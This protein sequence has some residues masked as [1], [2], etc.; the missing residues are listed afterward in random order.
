MASAVIVGAFESQLEKKV[1]LAFFLPGVV[2]M[3][4]AVGTQTETVLIG[5]LSIGVSVRSVLRRELVTDPDRPRAGG[6]L[7][8]I[9]AGGLGRRPCR[10]LALFSGSSIATWSLVV[11]ALRLRPRL[12]VGTAGDGHTGPA[13]H[14]RLLRDSVGDRNLRSAVRL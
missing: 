10:G 1:L 11:P 12:R 14:R 5:G 13:L 7:L 8:P 6:R 2:Y 9:R 3:A 4:D